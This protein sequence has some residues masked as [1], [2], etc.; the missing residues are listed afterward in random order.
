MIVN[1]FLIGNLIIIL[2]DFRFQLTHNLTP[3][4]IK[5]LKLD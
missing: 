3:E 4:I 1:V 5:I 2:I